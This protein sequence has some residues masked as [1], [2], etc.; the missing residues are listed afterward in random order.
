MTEE[1]Q[2]VYLIG[3]KENEYSIWEMDKFSG[4]SPR[5]SP[6]YGFLKV[7][8]SSNPE[9]R[10]SNMQSATPHTLELITTIETPHPKKVEEMLHRIFRPYSCTGEWFK[11]TENQ[12]NSL[13]AI[14]RLNLSDLE[15]ISSSVLASDKTLY[16]R[17]MEERHD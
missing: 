1:Q 8:I 3:H 4:F 12:I 2:V 14:D 9:T 5:P 15:G 6:T 11:L 16:L 17:V 13:K 10:V 7:G